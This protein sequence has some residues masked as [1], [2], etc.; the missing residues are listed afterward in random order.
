M[1]TT[2]LAST[3]KGH[4]QKAER[5]SVPIRLLIT[6]HKELKILSEKQQRSMSFIAMRRYLAGRDQELLSSESYI[7]NNSINNAEGAQNVK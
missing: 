4:L 3:K 5:V 6:D 2:A 1:S 7:T